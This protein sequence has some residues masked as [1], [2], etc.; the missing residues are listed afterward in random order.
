MIVS[1]KLTVTGRDLGFF[2][3]ASG[4]LLKLREIEGKN[5]FD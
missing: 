3:E 1:L 2:E 4:K 5:R